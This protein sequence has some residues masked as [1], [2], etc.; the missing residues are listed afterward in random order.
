[1][2]RVNSNVKRSEFDYRQL[3]KSNDLV[4]SNID[5][6]DNVLGRLPEGH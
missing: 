1:M 3:N 5:E 6:P 2:D 4:M